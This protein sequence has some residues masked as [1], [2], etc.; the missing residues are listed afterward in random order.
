MYE[1][2]YM[3]IFFKYIVDQKKNWQNWELIADAP[4]IAV[5]T[6]NDFIESMKEA[7]KR[8]IDL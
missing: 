5:E 3:K 2:D 6:F 4:Q 7:E 8:G 1:P